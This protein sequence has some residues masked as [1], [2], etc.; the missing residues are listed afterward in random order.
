MLMSSGIITQFRG[1]PKSG[2]P[3][4]DEINAEINGARLASSPVKC[5]NWRSSKLKTSHMSMTGTI[6]SNLE[7]TRT[8]YFI[9]ALMRP[10]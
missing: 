3:S 7:N 5:P 1:L 6:Q 10:S 4:K 2:T 9:T 8:A